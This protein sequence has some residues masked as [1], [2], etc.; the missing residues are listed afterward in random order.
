[1]TPL[2][3]VNVVEASSFISGPFAAM[4]LADLGAEVTKVEPPRG[5][6]YRRVGKTYGDASLEFKATNQNKTSTCLDLKTSAGFAELMNL[7]STADVFISNWR[8]SVA[9]SFG[10]IAERLLEDFPRLIWIRVSGYGQ[11]GPQADLPAYD[12]IIQARSGYVLEGT[13]V[14][15]QHNNNVADKVTAMFATQTAIAALL[16]RSASGSGK[17]CDLAM[18]DALAY[19]YGADISAPYRAERVDLTSVSR[20]SNPVF[21]TADGYIVVS[22]VSGRQLRRALEAVGRGDYFSRVMD[23]EKPKILETFSACLAP[24]LLHK[25][26]EEWE[27]VFRSADVPAAAVRTFADHISD[28][29]MAHNDTYREVEDRDVGSFKQVRYPSLF[30]GASAASVRCTAPALKDD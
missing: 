22:P 21:P 11:S 2:A 6:P 3:G 28:E 25:S 15:M 5:D 12:S 27:Q 23:S 20:V 7:L 10:L 30:N 13:D 17:V 26:A 8:P 14:P 24:E 18:V 16:E 1:M 4:M 29:Q 19:F 9:E